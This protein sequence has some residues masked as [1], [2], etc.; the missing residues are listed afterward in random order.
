MP[1]YPSTV[2]DL[3]KAGVIGS[4]EIVA[5]VDLYMRAPTAGPYCFAGGHSVDIA[6]A[7][8]AAPE[9]TGSKVSPGPQGKALRKA[10]TATVM[11]A[12]AVPPSAGR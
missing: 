4:T 2:A 3:R 1:P 5:A 11:M 12:Q 6:G 10:V 9:I 8:A 7:V